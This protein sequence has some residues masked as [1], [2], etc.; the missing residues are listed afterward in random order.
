MV[1]VWFL[2]DGLRGQGMRGDDSRGGV[3]GDE[4][5][6][7]VGMLAG[8]VRALGLVIF[9]CW[10]YLGTPTILI[11]G[12]GSRGGPILAIAVCLCVSFH[13]FNRIKY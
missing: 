7:S 3:V 1:G 4:R 9:R 2:R 5:E 6:G 11:Q 12:F 10:M 13:F 8:R